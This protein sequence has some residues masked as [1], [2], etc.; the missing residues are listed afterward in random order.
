MDAVDTY[1]N[2]GKK[3]SNDEDVMKSRFLARGSLLTVVTKMCYGE[4]GILACQQWRDLLSNPRRLFQAHYRLKD[5]DISAR[6]KK[7]P[8]GLFALLEPCLKERFTGPVLDS[9]KIIGDGV[10]TFL[11]QVNLKS[12]KGFSRRNPYQLLAAR[13]LA[14]R[15]K[16]AETEGP[17]TPH[18]LVPDACNAFGQIALMLREALNTKRNLAVGDVYIRRIMQGLRPSLGEVALNEDLDQFD[19]IRFDNRYSGLLRSSFTPQNLTTAAG[20]SSLLA[21][22]S[23]GLG[24][25]TSEFLHSN[26]MLFQTLEDCV[27]TFRQAVENGV[28]CCNIKI[29]GRP[30]AHMALTGGPKKRTTLEDKFEEYFRKDVQD[31]WLQLLGDLAGNNPETYEGQKPRYG[32]IKHWLNAIKLTCFSSGLTPLQFC[33]NAVD[34]KICDPP[35]V[36]EVAAWV[37]ENRHLGAGN[38]LQALGFQADLRKGVEAA[39]EVVYW[40]LE[41]HLHEE[42]KA[43]LRFSPIFVEHLLCKVARFSRQFESKDGTLSQRGSTAMRDQLEAGGWEKGANIQDKAGRLYPIPLTV[44]ESVVTRVVEGLKSR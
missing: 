44:D 14:K 15:L 3:Y 10:W 29:W 18:S 43:V 36:E 42:D 20:V 39:F 1:F 35:E 26:T 9:I 22:M 23:A 4:D 32:D 30:C 24:Y 8:D 41:Q 28:E 31:S 12:C 34:L 6:V 19:I 11:R 37:G 38:G 7:D 13:P 17:I 40:H 21:Y 5:R 2:G 16:Q 33:N 27:T 25:M